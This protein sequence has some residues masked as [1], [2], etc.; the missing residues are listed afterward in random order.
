MQWDIT[1]LACWGPKPDKPEIITLIIL[2]NYRYNWYV[3]TEDVQITQNQGH[4]KTERDTEVM[5]W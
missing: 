5:F 3:H 2:A 4:A 1:I